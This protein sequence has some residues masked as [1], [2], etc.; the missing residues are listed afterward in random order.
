MRHNAA[1][2]K[3]LRGE[4]CVGVMVQFPSPELIELYALMGFEWAFID[5]EHGP[6]GYHEC[7]ALVR[8]CDAYGL[9]SMVRVPKLDHSLIAK[10]L[11]TGALGVAVPHIK[12]PEDAEAV[13]RAARYYPEGRR[14]WDAG[15]SRSSAY[16]L[17]MPSLDYFARSNEEILVALWIE[18][19]E[20]IENLDAIL[21]V[22][23]V[24]VINFGVG[25][26]TLSMGLPAQFDHPEVKATVAEGRRKVVEAGKVLIGEA[27]DAETARRLVDQG[28]RLISTMVNAM[29]AKTVR[30]YLAELRKR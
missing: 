25:D 10:Y 9:S 20:G 14:G 2:Q 19:V 30:E 15:A 23:G 16:N 6:L 5:A 22:P 8:A 1:K 7:Q 13:V 18:D 28:A 26:L 24:D 17:S 21:Q 12:T 3:V 4:P 29:L 27:A 11:E